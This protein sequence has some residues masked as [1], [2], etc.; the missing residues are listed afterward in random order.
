M[1][2]PQGGEATTDRPTASRAIAGGKWTLV[3]FGGSQFIRFVCNLALARLLLDADAD[4]GVIAV[5]NSIVQALQLL[6]DLG[7]WVNLVQSRDGDKREYLDTIWTIQVVRGVLLF[8]IGW[9][10]APVLAAEYPGMPELEQ[11]VRITMLGV[12][13]GAFVPTSFHLAGRNLRLGPVAIIELGSQLAG[14]VAMIALATVLQSPIGLAVGSP[15]IVV[16]RVLL[17]WILLGGGNRPCWDRT[18]AAA[19]FRF[20]KWV[21]LATIVFYVTTHADRLLYGKL[22]TDAQLG[23][24]SIALALAW[25]PADITTRLSNAVVFPLLCRAAQDGSDYGRAVRTTRAPALALGGWMFSGVAGG[26]PAA[27][28]LLYPQAFADAAWIVPILCIG[29]WFGIVLENSNGCVLLALGQPRWNTFASVAKLVALC[30]LL[31]LGWQGWGF[32]GAIGAYALADMVRY[33]TL[34]WACRRT[35]VNTL[36]ADLAASARM[37]ACAF[38]C[39]V[40]A[41]GLPAAGVHPALTCLVVAL[42]ATAAWLPGNVGRLLQLRAKGVG[43]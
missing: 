39:A 13:A 19:I 16:L 42:V 8:A 11:C 20:G 34:Q 26:A 33:A 29:F 3:A 6:S 21:S 41:L 35:G 22:V 43:Q 38:A 23:V 37:V 24:Y 14:S 1:T 36:G 7:I 32:P 2:E 18:H 17:S 9:S 4:F 27:V 28:A 5:A 10:L 31:P 25:I 40:P 12:L 30:V 15:L